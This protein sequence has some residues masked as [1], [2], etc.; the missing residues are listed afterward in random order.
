MTCSAC[1]ARV[2][3]AVNCLSG[4]S[5]VQVNLLTNSM[6]VDY[7]PQ[8]LSDAQIITAVEKAGYGASVKGTSVQDKRSSDN[9]VSAAEKQRKAMR[10]RMIWSFVFLIPLMYVSMGHMI[11]LPLPSFLHGA[12]NG[13]SFAFAQFLLCLPVAIINSGYYTRGWKNLFRLSPNMDSL[14]AVGSTASLVY[15][16]ISI[17]IMSHALGKG[18]LETVKSR[19]SEL[20]FESAVMILALVNLGKYLE[21]KSKSRTSEAITGLI[22]LSPKTAE[23]ERDGQTLTIPTSEL[24]KGDVVIV[25]AGQSIPCDGVIIHGS[26]SIDQ[27]AITG[28]SIPVEKTQ[29]DKVIGATISK[30]GFIKLRATEVGNDTTLSKIISLVDEAS[31]SKAP[32][33]KLAD[34]TAGVFVPIVMLISLVTAI[35]WLCVGADTGFALSCAISVLVISCPCAL[36]LATPVAIM[37]GTGKG[38]KSGILIKSGDALQTLRSANTVVLDKTGTVTTGKPN[39]TAVCPIDSTTDELL[40]IALSL[41]QNSEH[42]LAKAVCEY[43]ANVKAPAAENF[44][45]HSGLGVSAVV[46]G[47][48]YFAGNERFLRENGVFKSSDKLD[49]ALSSCVTPLFF[50]SKDKMLGVIS[51]EDT[52]KPDSAAAVRELKQ[53]GIEVVLLTGD[54]RTAAN[55][56]AS[57]IDPDKTVA[58]VLPADKDK[59]VSELQ[60]QGRIVAMVGDGINDAPALVR[61][62]VGIAIGAGT[63]IAIDSADVVLMKNSL[64][65]VVTA[66]DLSR[67]VIRNIKQNLFWAFFYNVLAIPLAAGAYYHL[68]G[69]KLDPMIG[70]A[71]MS[72][73]SIFVVTNALRLRRFRPSMPQTCQQSNNSI[74][75]V[76][77]IKEEETM[78]NYTMK[79]KGM[80]CMHCVAH[81]KKALEDKGASAEVDL[82]K[83]EAYIK[84]DENISTQALT[85]AVTDAGY[86][87]LSIN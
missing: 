3:K 61:S 50:A 29:G 62:D 85:Q 87:V 76:S 60:S 12:Q 69:W 36:G 47:I 77:N 6:S 46:N 11:S 53:R 82:D 40:Q 32:I 84:A 67:S 34:K 20:Y 38:A 8:K 31:S 57:V 48:E 9:A 17:F 37:V 75:T 68:L 43:C 28:E 23:V 15:S 35:I 81:V 70:A 45:T 78:K 16:I 41:E 51:V 59:V 52:V 1:S 21:A 72:L 66:I 25:R 19:M 18:D 74:N 33:A 58:E 79:I 55:K 49:D 14:I 42:P 64:C 39:V 56:V 73:S 4:M 24:E 54:N 27:S 86:E 71:A 80:M 63:D 10:S 22:D 30:S 26:A 7:D 13:V 65:D 5:E 83:G 44:T 2:E